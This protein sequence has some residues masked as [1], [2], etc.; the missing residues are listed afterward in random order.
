MKKRIY[1]YIVCYTKS[2][3]LIEQKR[4][5]VNLCQKL[6]NEYAN[7]VDGDN[8]EIKA[9]GY[10]DPECECVVT[11]EFIKKSAD[12]VIFLFDKGSDYKQKKQIE[13]R[14]KKIVKR[15]R[16]FHH[17]EILVYLPD[18]ETKDKLNENT[19]KLLK[20][21]SINIKQ[22]EEADH[23]KYVEDNKVDDI[24]E[25]IKKE[26]DLKKFV[27][28]NIRAYVNSYEML[29]H[30]K[31]LRIIL[32]V[33]ILAIISSI[34]GVLIWGII[35]KKMADYESQKRILI[36][37]GG[38]AKNLI[39]DYA[40][41]ENAIDGKF[42]IYAPLPTGDAY[43]LLTEETEMNES[44]YLNRNYYTVIF[45]AGMADDTKFLR[46]GTVG[47]DSISRKDSISI[48][49]RRKSILEF[50]KTGVIIGI[51]IGMD[52]LSFYT[53]GCHISNRMEKAKFKEFI[54]KADSNIIYTTNLNSGTFK[55]YQEITDSTIKHS[56]KRIF[57]SSNPIEG[58]SWIALGSVY[59]KPDFEEKDVVRKTIIT[60]AEPKPIYI[61]FMRYRNGK[62]NTYD[63]PEEVEIFLTDIGI[64]QNTIENIKND[65]VPVAKDTVIL[66]DYFCVD[67][68]CKNSSHIHLK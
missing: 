52:S 10:V 49:I 39:F 61:Y 57:Y 64:P 22:Y 23:E 68:T 37:G 41:N 63:L 35:N 2:D 51:H 28:D 54:E 66:F 32:Y 7:Q 60:D 38:S 43:H 25:K 31:R 8:I 4:C 34:L 1:L 67:T 56:D 19:K 62:K 58:D 9:V 16:Y 6:N 26:N 53:K 20:D 45:S 36:S 15:Y 65:P 14:L 44:S 47:K 40:H 48:A 59:Y 3:N 30:A 18:K 13:N 55:Q 21:N 33:I 42:R 50:R 5:I 11:E 12:I 27:E 24:I 29:N 17:P 46:C